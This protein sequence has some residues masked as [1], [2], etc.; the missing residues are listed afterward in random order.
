MSSTPQ[1]PQQP[2]QQP[3]SNPTQVATMPPAYPP[4]YNPELAG[5]AHTSAVVVSQPS[6]PEQAQGLQALAEKVMQAKPHLGVPPQDPQGPSATVKKEPQLEALTFLRMAVAQ[7][8]SD[9]HFRIGYPPIIRKDGD[10][11]FTKLPPLT[12]EALEAFLKEVVPAEVLAKIQGKTDFDFGFQIPGL[13]RFRV[14]WF[15]EFNQVGLVLR[16]VK[17]KIADLKTLGLPPS[18]ESL[19][20][21]SKGLVLVTGP[22]G[23][24]KST[25]LAALLNHINHTQSKHIITLED[26]V[27]YVYTNQ[28]SAVTQRQLGI[29]TDSFPNGIKYALRQDPDV[30]LVGEMRDRATVNAAL[31]AAETGHMV[32]S[33]LHTI[34]SVQT[35]NRIINLFDPH[36]REQIRHQLASVLQ[37]T[38]SQ[39][40]VKRADG[41]GRTVVFEVL[42][43][44]PAVRDYIARYQ[45][46]EIYHLLDS[47][48]FQGSCSLNK[49]L[50]NAYHEGRVSYE[51]A[52]D[53]AEN[54][55]EM[56]QMLRGFYSGNR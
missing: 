42:M 37:G 5:S 4:G 46:D 29:D 43:V 21:C 52:L 6:T 40:L 36:E 14:N 25:T 33:T 48:E 12:Q 15:Y 8:I 50:Y 27:E 41:N 47:N 26:P 23:S 19:T 2:H 45:L 18:L 35:I 11:L 55:T 10:I 9:I 24:G 1:Q 3:P 17:H 51:D 30:I 20:T 28:K 49:C 38:I 7:D 56:E 31:H 44:T 39:R 53:I 22:T 16:I 32:F 34:D 54:K 13:A